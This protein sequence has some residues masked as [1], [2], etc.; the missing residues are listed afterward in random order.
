MRMIGEAN[1]VVF[2]IDSTDVNRF[3]E[4]KLSFDSVCDH[5]TLSK[6]P[7]ITF[8]N[9]QDLQVCICLYINI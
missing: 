6:V 5:E 7:I 9:K 3:Q 4:A 8:A 1:A 2:V